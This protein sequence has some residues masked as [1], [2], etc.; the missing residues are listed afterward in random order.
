MKNIGRPEQFLESYRNICNRENNGQTKADDEAEEF[1]NMNFVRRLRDSMDRI[2][3][4][5]DL[6]SINL[7]A[8]AGCCDRFLRVLVDNMEWR[9]LLDQIM[10]TKPKCL[11][12]ACPL[13]KERIALCEILSMDLLGPLEFVDAIE[14]HLTVIAARD[15]FE[16]YFSSLDSSQYEFFKS[17]NAF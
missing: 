11:K 8:A 10:A 13:Q 3:K 16:D 2:N 14:S 12:T 5:K 15:C 1:W 9:P 4:E 6:F 7:A 17:S